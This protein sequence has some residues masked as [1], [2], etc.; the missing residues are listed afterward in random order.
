MVGIYQITSP[1]NKVYIGQSWNITTRKNQYKFLRC[2]DQPAIYNSL[3]KHGFNSHTFKVIHQLPKDINQ[4]ILD[5]YE[6]IYM[7]FN[8]DCGIELLNIREGGSYGKHSQESKEKIS[9]FWK[10]RQR[11]ESWRLNIS[12][13]KK[14]KP[15]LKRLGV[16]HSQE[17]KDKLRMGMEGRYSGAN[18]PFYGKKVSEEN[19]I[20]ASERMKGRTPGNKG[21]KYPMSEESKKRLMETRRK[22]YR[23]SEETKAKMRESRYR[24]NAKKLLAALK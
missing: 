21:K 6:Q 15:N 3:K 13:G 7:D 18:S 5:R 4:E 20:K 10:G 14:G 17:T 2:V 11:A 22:N 8:K 12:K 1:T 16:K 9:K 19:K 23:H 24:F